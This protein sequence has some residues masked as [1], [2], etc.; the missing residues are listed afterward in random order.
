MLAGAHPAVRQLLGEAPRPARLG[1][2]PG[3]PFG[4]PRRGRLG[5]AAGP[6]GGVLGA[7]P[8]GVEQQVR[9]SQP[10]SGDVLEQPPGDRGAEIDRVVLGPLGVVLALDDVAAG[11]E[12]L[13]GPGHHRLDLDVHLGAVD[14]VPGPQVGQLAPAQPG[15]DRHVEQQL[16]L[17]AVVVELPPQLRPLLG[18][19]HRP[20]AAQR[21]A[22]RSAHYVHGVVRPQAAV[23]G[24]L[25]HRRQRRAV[26]DAA[27]QRA[28]GLLRLG[29][30]GADHRRRDV[31]DRHGAEARDE[32][33]RM[34][35]V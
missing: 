35:E 26:R 34:C 27:A 4:L 5:V 24:P 7:D 25:Q 10:L 9:G 11:A 18:L 30:P 1:G 8:V 15:V 21:G 2:E 16:R 33:G 22:R 13:A 29:H 12:L 28:A 32:V 14:D 23:D 19:E 31:G 20:P 3:L 17:R 6:P